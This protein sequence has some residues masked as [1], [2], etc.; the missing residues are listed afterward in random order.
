MAQVGLEHL[1]KIFQGPDSASIRA[2]DDLCLVVEHKEL[3]VL[4]GPSGCGKTTTLRLIAGLEEPSAGT[5]SING[6]VANH[7]PPKARDVAMVFQHHALYP[8]MSVYE[9]IAFGLKLRHLPRAEIDQRVKEAAQVLD[10]TACLDRK[11]DALSGGQRQ[12]VALGRAIVRRPGVFLLDEPLSN[13]DAQTRL[14]MRAELSRLHTRLGSTMIY[15][16]H[17]Q[18]E[19]LTLGHRVAV[20]KDGVIQQIGVPMDVYERPANLFVAG[21]IGSPP[22]NFLEGTASGHGDTLVFQAQIAAAVAPQY[23]LTLKLDSVSAHRLRDYVGKPI[24][25]GLRPEHVTCATPPLGPPKEDTLVAVVELIQPVGSETY[26][27]LAVPGCSLI[28]RVPA[29]GPF[30]VGQRVPLALNASQARFFDPASGTAI[31]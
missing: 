18:I 26:L 14:Q 24:I 15:V 17:D 6:Q 13:L 25:L 21:F 2:V 23:P 5:V 19:A 31:A 8:H 1:T 7:L 4:V 29:T 10:L 27:H 20:M 16:T 12:R 9:N 28:A 3:L 11:P 22:M 30:N